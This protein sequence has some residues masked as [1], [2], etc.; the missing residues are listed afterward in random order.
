VSFRDYEH[1]R[2][3]QY[4]LGN[5]AELIVLPAALEDSYGVAALI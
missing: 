3:E 4:P 1:G 2:R 5:G